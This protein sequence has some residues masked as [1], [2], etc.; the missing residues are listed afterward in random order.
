MP[1]D[2]TSDQSVARDGAR[3]TSGARPRRR[4]RTVH[5]LGLLLALATIVLLVSS[6]LGLHPFGW[7]ADVVTN[8]RRIP[9]RYIALACALKAL[10]SV[11]TAIS[12]RNV[13]RAAFP[14]SAVPFR[15]VFGAYQG[16]VGINAVTPA[17][18]GSWVMLGLFRVSIRGASIA[19]LVAAALVQGL[20][21]SLLAVAP[22][23][24]LM[25]GD[26]NAVRA[27]IESA[28]R[29]AVT[30]FSH[31]AALGILTAVALLLALILARWLRGRLRN[32]WQQILT[33]GA[34]LRTPRRFV[35][36]VAAPQLAS[37]LCRLGYTATFMAAFDIPVTL[38]TVF[39]VVASGSI[40]NGVQITPGGVGSTEAILVVALRGYASASD[41]TAFSLAK[42]S[43]LTIWNLL[44]GFSA[45]S[46]GFGLARAGRILRN[47]HR[48][49][50]QTRAQSADR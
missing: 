32:L 44:F 26:P 6:L 42:T 20:F 48:I 50:A 12:W 49:S 23:L 5:K 19:S 27:V 46:W 17:N 2:P 24:V 18:A 14:E 33:G 43:I 25:V 3:S 1:S 15:V 31:P 30:L 38:R 10:E 47:R 4:L 7:I 28:G 40:A 41:V 13:L 21:F 37:Y 11:L 22:W 16:G 39:L 35:T 9:P 29:L 34:V 8:I 36:G 45:L